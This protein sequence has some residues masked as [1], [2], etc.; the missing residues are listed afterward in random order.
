MESR[1]SMPRAVHAILRRWPRGTAVA[2]LPAWPAPGE[3]REGAA[4]QCLAYGLAGRP[5]PADYWMTMRETDR[6]PPESAEYAALLS[7]LR[8]AGYAP[9]LLDQATLA[10]HDLRYARAGLHRPQFANAPTAAQG[11]AVASSSSTAPSPGRPHR[12]VSTPIRI[13]SYVRDLFPHDMSAT[14]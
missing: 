13:A 8:A 9:T 7:V 5:L 11:H 2:L 10:D 14:A 6:L 12:V 4:G 1:C 3:P